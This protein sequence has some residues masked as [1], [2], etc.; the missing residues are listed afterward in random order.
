MSA[1]HEVKASWGG[2]SFWVSAIQGSRPRRIAK[3][4]GA[5]RDGATTEDMGRNPRVEVFTVYLDR[6]TF[7]KLENA[8]DTKKVQLFTHPIFGS[9]NAR[10]NILNYSK[11]PKS[12]LQVSIEVTE[13]KAQALSAD[14]SDSSPDKQRH[15]RM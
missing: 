8:V 5:F 13:E 10:L 14:Y 4:T 12:L 6:D 3:Y 2:V 11:G 9:F 7:I 1:G 15:G